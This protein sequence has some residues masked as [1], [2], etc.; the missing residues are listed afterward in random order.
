[1]HMAARHSLNN[2]QFR[3]TPYDGYSDEPSPAV[4]ARDVVNNKHVGYLSWNSYGGGVSTVDVDPKYRNRGIATHMWELAQQA[5][6]DAPFHYPEI[7]HSTFRSVEGD[8]WA[9]SLWEKGLAGEVPYNDMN[10]DPDDPDYDPKVAAEYD[11][12]Y[13]KYKHLYR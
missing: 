10:D 8:A 4:H 7:E 2:I 13:E 5:H 3:I 11:A 6:K 12:V 9:H 1:M